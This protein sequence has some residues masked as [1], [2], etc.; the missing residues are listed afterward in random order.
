MLRL[1]FKQNSS[2]LL[3]FSARAL[4]IVI[5]AF[6][7]FLSW[8]GLGKEA[9]L[10]EAGH[11]GGCVCELLTLDDFPVTLLHLRAVSLGN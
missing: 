4:E 9:V 5:L 11:F 2:E 3:W 8:G 6:L 1:I 10:C 7:L